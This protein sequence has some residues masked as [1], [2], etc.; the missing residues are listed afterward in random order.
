MGGWTAL[1]VVRCT[2]FV[3]TLAAMGRGGA[4]WDAA[5]VA[6][7]EGSS[8]PSRCDGWGARS[9]VV[10]GDAGL[11]DLGVGA[12]VSRVTW[13]AGLSSRRPRK[14][15]WR[16]RLS[17]VQVAKRT[18]A[19]SV[20]LT[21]WAPVNAPTGGVTERSKGLVERARASSLSR[22]SLWVFWVKPVPV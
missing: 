7:E 6:G 19:T 5:L 16:T 11:E 1:S 3:A 10:A 15:A 18:W 9:C 2:F 4:A 14:A 17:A 22:R 13:A 12:E 8:N 21:Q 20:G